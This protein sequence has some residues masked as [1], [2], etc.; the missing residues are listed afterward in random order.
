MRRVPCLLQIIGTSCFDTVRNNFKKSVKFFQANDLTD[1]VVKRLQHLF[2]KLRKLPPKEGEIAGGNC[3]FGSWWVGGGQWD[4][5]NP[6]R[7]KIT[8][9]DRRSDGVW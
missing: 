1:Y 4:H 7:Q 8:P 2:M 9:P 3:G 6:Q 5:G